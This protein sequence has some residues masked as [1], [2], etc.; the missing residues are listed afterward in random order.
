[1]S[2]ESGVLEAYLLKVVKESYI[3]QLQDV[4]EKFVSD[5]NKLHSK[6]GIKT[7]SEI[8]K[9]IQELIR[10][11]FHAV[12]FYAPSFRAIR[13]NSPQKL[14]N[15]ILNKAAETLILEVTKK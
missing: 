12:G 10:V 11:D 15:D 14:D 13:E 4:I 9:F 5:V 1:M 8:E 2:K 7:D 6:F 3:D